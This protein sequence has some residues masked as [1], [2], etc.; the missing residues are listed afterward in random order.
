MLSTQVD[1]IVANLSK[2]KQ[3]A[4]LRTLQ[5][6]YKNIIQHPNNV[7]YQQIKLTGKLFSSTVW[8]CPAC[9]I[10]MMMSGWVVEK[11]Y[12][13]LRD[14]SSVQIVL[15]IISLKLQV[16]MINFLLKISSYI[17]ACI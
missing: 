8:Q 9:R 4:T 2:E 5:R 16:S 6:I 3:E 13:K 14:D 15:A 7:K 1:K 11:N 17:T 12:V 10:L